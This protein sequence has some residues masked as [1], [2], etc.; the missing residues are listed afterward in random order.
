MAWDFVAKL[1]HGF[2]C[3]VQFHFYDVVRPAY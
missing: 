2:P 3:F 1:G